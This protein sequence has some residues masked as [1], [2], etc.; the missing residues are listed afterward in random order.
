[1]IVDFSERAKFGEIVCGMEMLSAEFF[2]E[3]GQ[4][5]S[6]NDCGCF[7]VSLHRFHARFCIASI[8]SGTQADKRRQP[9]THCDK[10]GPQPGSATV[11]V[12][13]RMDS[14]PLGVRPSTQVEDCIELVGSE[15][16]ADRNIAV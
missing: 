13:K 8:G 10:V 6:K 12:R 11:S 4:Q 9:I 1:M 15:L 16:P 5:S 14:H 3:A 2:Q 7:P